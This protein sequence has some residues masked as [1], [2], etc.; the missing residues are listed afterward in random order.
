ML[1]MTAN[2]TLTAE[3]EAQLCELY[4]LIF[5]S[6]NP[7]KFFDKFNYHSQFLILIA[8][9]ND[10]CVGFKIGYG[11]DCELFY[12]W[13]GG[14]HP[15]YRKR[16]IAEALM[17]KQHEWCRI[18]NYSIIETRTRNKFPEMIQL[19]FKHD[20]KIVGTFIDV[21]QE[22]KIILRKNIKD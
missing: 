2:S 7:E 18:N 1:K 3:I 14:V 6:W 19:N 11:Q 8:Y 15:D 12:S 20:F 5:S 22:P 17:K 16:G 13:T 9:W 4:P 21:D 10:K